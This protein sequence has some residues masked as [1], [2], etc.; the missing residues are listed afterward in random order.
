[1]AVY[2]VALFFA[3]VFGLG[4]SLTRF[5]KNSEDFFERQFMRLGFGLSA[6]I[7][8]AI[9][10]N[11]LQVP[12]DWRIFLAA[13]VLPAAA[14]AAYDFL[15]KQE[16]ISLPKSMKTGGIALLVALAVFIFAMFMYAAGSFRYPY[17]ED[18]DPWGHSVGA[19][20]V[21]IEKKAFDPVGYN[22]AYI[23]PY[24]PGYDILMGVLLQADSSVR[25]ILK[26]FNA[27]IISLGLLWFFFMAKNFVGPSKAA[28]AAFA[29]AMIP[30]YFTHFI[31]A[32]TLVI[33]LFFPAMYAFWRIKDDKLWS[34]PAALCVAAIL[35]V[36]PDQPL[37]LAV[38]VL[39][40]IAVRA[41]SARALPRWEVAAGL[42]GVLISL[43][44]WAS[45]AQEMLAYAMGI[46][47]HGSAF[48]PE[49][50]SA[51]R[52]YSLADYLFPSQTLINVPPG[53]GLV[54]SILLVAGLAAVFLNYRKLL[55]GEKPW[56]AVV[57]LWFGFTFIGTNSVTF[58]LPFGLNPFRFWLL[59]AI[60]VAILAAEGAF[61]LSS[62]L[63]AFGPA[64]L[65][66]I[67]LLAFGVFYTSGLFK[68]GINMAPGWYTALDPQRELPGYLA[69]E[70]LPA[71]TGVIS[72]I[73][74]SFIIGMDKFSCAWCPEVV[75]FKKGL[76]HASPV[77][78]RSF[79][80][81]NGYEYLLM[82]AWQPADVP[83]GLIRNESV[84]LKDVELVNSTFFIP[85]A[86]HLDG[87]V[88]V[89]R[90]R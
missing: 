54:V 34:I 11:A 89:F 50:G 5:V 42:G 28:F 2:S 52:A 57:L 90:L 12:L 14:F 26:F 87:A 30:S 6:F 38:M 29:L 55:R 3:I 67:L 45:N 8:L 15:K 1:M 19:K 76:L 66:F 16:V 40:F 82:N 31:W 61:F 41:W 86:A 37:K 58:N 62:P 65:A 10:L 32:H 73:D 78:V 46:G 17:L 77:E 53:F 21:S 64:R 13:S 60:P 27:L 70:R 33:A 56:L 79:M 84:M 59:L 44:W 88:T 24:P 72:N 9:L 18:E 20:Y 49:G 75:E 71:N 22:F 36:Q 39:A 35:L 68:L 48:S 74:D 7:V 85:V 69:L 23:D 83:G 25:F 4:Y 81:E 47:K 51:S 80:K 43:A 63:R